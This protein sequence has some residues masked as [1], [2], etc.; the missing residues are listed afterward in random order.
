[1]LQKRILAFK[2]HERDATREID[3]EVTEKKFGKF[4]QEM[5]LLKFKQ[6]ER[7]ATSDIQTK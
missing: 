3:T 7:L 4:K 1:M 6:N 5:Q 2:Q